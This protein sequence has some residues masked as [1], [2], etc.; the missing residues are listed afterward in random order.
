[1][2]WPQGMWDLSSLTRDQT[3]AAYIGGLRFNYWTAREVVLVWISFMCL[4][5]IYISSLKKCLWPLLIYE[6]GCFLLL[7]VRDSLYIL[8]I[9]L[10]QTYGLQNFPPLCGFNFYS[11]DSVLTHKI[12]KVSRNSVCL[13]FFCCLRFSYHMQVI[14][15]TTNEV[16][17]FCHVFISKTFIDFGFYTVVSDPFLVNF[18][19]VLDKSPSSFL[20]MWMLSFPR[21]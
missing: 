8:D 3:C 10:H 2:F 9:T 21:T 13:L 6:L 11:P 19:M 5:V 14:I 17:K 15:A 1:M 12:L 20:F 4:L 7:S 16:M 18:Y